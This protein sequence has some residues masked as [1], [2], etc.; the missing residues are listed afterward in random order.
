MWGEGELACRKGVINPLPQ[1]SRL[2][3]WCLATLVLIVLFVHLLGWLSSFL[4]IYRLVCYTH[5]LHV[6]SGAL[7]E[8]IGITCLCTL[9]FPLQFLYKIST[10]CLQ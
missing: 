7:D 2:G 5:T 9:F 6:C 4:I 8:G 1:F 3:T 10:H